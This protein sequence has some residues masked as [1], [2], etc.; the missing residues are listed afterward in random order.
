MASKSLGVSNK[1]FL[2]QKE[3]KDMAKTILVEEVTLEEQTLPFS[4]DVQSVDLV[5]TGRDYEEELMNDWRSY[6]EFE[7]EL[8]TIRVNCLKQ[9]ELKP[10]IQAILRKAPSAKNVKDNIQELVGCEFSLWWDS[11]GKRYML[12]KVVATN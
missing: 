12:W 1:Y 3:D 5:I 10:V 9:T 11:E 4:D 8:F 7:P 6:K 2:F